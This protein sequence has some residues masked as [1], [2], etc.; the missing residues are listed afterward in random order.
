[1]DKFDV[2]VIG[3]GVVGSSTARY[4]SQY[5]INICVLEKATDVCEGTSKA[6]SGIVHAGFDALPGTKKA[7]FNLKGSLMMEELSRELEFAYRRNGS[8]VVSFDTE[9][10]SKLLELKKRGERNGVQG[11][12]I[13]DASKVR[14]MEPHISENVAAALWAPTG[15]VVDPF[16]L[17]IAM[18]ENACVNGAE[19]R[20][21]TEV[22]NISKSEEGFIVSTN[23]GDIFAKCVINCAGVYSDKI[24]NMVCE[25]KLSI[26]S[27]KGEYCLY[28][29]TVGNLVNSTVFQL[30]SKMGKGVLVTP[31]VHGNLLIG[32]TAMDTDDKEEVNTTAEGLKTVQAVGALS[33]DQIPTKAVITSFAGL[34]AHGM[35]GDFVIGESSVEGFFDAAEIES[36]GLSAAPAI[37]EY[38]AE[39]VSKEL[40]AERKSDFVSK[41][42]GFFCMAAASDEEKK[43]KIE[44]N[45]LYANVVCRCALVTEGEIVDAIKRPLG[46]TTVDGVKR[47]TGA[48]LGRCQ[49]GFCL[50]VTVDILARELGVDVTIITKKGPGSEFVYSHK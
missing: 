5:K 2:V 31:T 43:K 1:M 26:T 22:L 10:M 7:F 11:L 42:K 17:T 28:D 27:R 36:P 50:P 14:K 9:D 35:S 39:E 46:A 13:L 8:L 19:F 6:N 18:A 25:D 23:K 32:P 33:V 49:S 16:G 20:F 30:P 45:I 34:R 40:N 15:A 4:L 3:A 21:S 47:R 38:L 41:R 24:H 37:G 48:G 12:E 29:T 44:E